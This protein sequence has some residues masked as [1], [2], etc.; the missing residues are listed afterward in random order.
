MNLGKI[1]FVLLA[2][3]L[4]QPL[5]SQDIQIES[6]SDENFVIQEIRLKEPSVGNNQFEALIKNKTD[7]I[8]YVVIDVRTECLGIG[9]TNWQHQVIFQINPLEER[10]LIDSY[11]ICTPIIGRIRISFGESDRYFDRKK[12]MLLSQTERS[13]NPPPENKFFWRKII[14]GS[15]IS[16]AESPGRSITQL[17]SFLNDVTPDRLQTIKSSLPDLITK[18]R[19]VKNPLRARL[20]GLTL[21]NRKVPKD[22]DPQPGQWTYGSAK[23]KTN[24]ERFKIKADVFT[25]S[26][27][28]ETRIAACFVSAASDFSQKKPLVILLS[29]N[30]PG[31]KESLINAAMYFASRG[32]HA[33]TMDRRESA[34]TL[35]SKEKFIPNFTDPVYDARRLL[36][37]LVWNPDYNIGKIGIYGISAGAGES[38]LTTIL[39]D[40]I[41]AAVLACGTTSFNQLFKND[42]WIPT[43]SG[44]IIYPELGLGNPA[45]GKLSTLEFWEYFEKA[46]PEHNAKAKEIYTDLFPE[47]EDLD[48]E[49]NAPLI[50]PVPCFIVSGA[51]DDQFNPAGVV[52]VDLAMQKA[53]E[54]YD[55]PECS[56]LFIQSR[57]G[58]IVNLQAAGLIAVFFDRWLK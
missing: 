7:E 8:K 9:N 26:G 16:V 49:K 14:N 17:T 31:T 29:G 11:F 3:V 57:A 40:R 21:A 44:M 58:H 54:E 28:G 6:Y 55:L 5:W 24:L 37:Y 13:K 50:A 12:W 1:F 2:T 41:D 48:P 52:E 23:I 15:D 30:P 20:N 4:I 22:F 35:D 33:I 27:E 34:R 32:Y 46:K 56:E 19:A 43:L 36:D 10:K 53:Y 47:F 38:M 18:S 51:R 25:I 42:G 45:V 39:D